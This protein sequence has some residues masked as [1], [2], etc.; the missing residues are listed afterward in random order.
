[1]ATDRPDPELERLVRQGNIYLLSSP[2]TNNYQTEDKEDLP[3]Y[4][5]SMTGIKQVI[6]LRPFIQLLQLNPESIFAS[7]TYP[8]KSIT[9]L[10]G[11]KPYHHFATRTEAVAAGK[12]AVQPSMQT[13]LVITCP[14]TMEDVVEGMLLGEVVYFDQGRLYE[15]RPN[16]KEQKVVPVKTNVLSM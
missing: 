4:V 12:T 9:E 11:L 6:A 10:L 7:D 14:Y 15:I 16:A 1:M 3:G 5:L 2:D 8:G 13:R